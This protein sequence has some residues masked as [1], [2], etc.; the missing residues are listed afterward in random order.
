MSLRAF[1]SILLYLTYKNESILI[2][3]MD[4]YTIL[5]VSRHDTKEEITKKYKKLALRFHPDR[6]KE[7]KKECEEKFKEISKAYNNIMNKKDF[8][9]NFDSNN[10]LFNKIDNFKQYFSNI[11]YKIVIKNLI[12]NISDYHDFIETQNSN[13]LKTED[14]YINARVELFDIY[15]SIEKTISIERI[16]KCELCKGLGKNINFETCFE[17]SGEKY[18]IKTLNLSF[19]CKHKNKIYHNYSHQEYNKIAGD[20]IINILVKPNINYDILN[21]YDLVYNYIVSQ[22]ELLLINSNEKTIN[23]N[24]KILNISFK[25]LDNKE[26]NFKIVNPQLNHKYQIN[27]MGLIK[28]NNIIERGELY[29]ILLEPKNKVIKTFISM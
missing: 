6:N 29:I 9:F 3:L 24:D 18:K 16:R 26:Y 1:K 25:H 20:V 2:I 14:F 15:N 4:D 12:N 7:N 17:C 28:N 10:T 27:N 11:N 8:N 19:N 5:G 23:S 22:Q 21:N 13:L